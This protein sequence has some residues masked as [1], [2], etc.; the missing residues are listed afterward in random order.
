MICPMT[1]SADGYTRSCLEDECALWDDTIGK[2]AFASIAF[3]IDCI[4]HEITEE[5]ARRNKE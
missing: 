5:I 4:H 3:A 2:C 1:R